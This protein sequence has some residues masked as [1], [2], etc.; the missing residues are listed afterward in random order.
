MFS[1]PKAETEPHVITGFIYCFSGPQS[2]PDM[3]SPFMPSHPKA[4]TEPHGITGFI[5]CFKYFKG[6]KMVLT[7]SLWSRQGKHDSSVSQMR[8]HSGSGRLDS[9]FGLRLVYT[10]SWSHGFKC[11]LLEEESQTCNWT[12]SSDHALKSQTPARP[13]FFPSPWACLVLRS[14]STWCTKPLTFPP[15]LPTNSLP[16]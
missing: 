10:N 14:S 13:A 5:H 4:E 7:R 2:L 1:H 6:L 8:K 16:T 12:P 11:H 3:L 9:A 15:N